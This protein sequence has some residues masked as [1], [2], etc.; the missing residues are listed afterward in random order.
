MTEPKPD[1]TPKKAARLEKHERRRRVFARLLWQGLDP[2]EAFCKAEYPVIGVTVTKG[3]YTP[4]Q[5]QTKAEAMRGEWWCRDLVRSWDQSP[6]DSIR[7]SLQEAADVFRMAMRQRGEDGLPTPSALRAAENVMDRGGYGRSQ[8]IERG[9]SDLGERKTR[10]EL[11]AAVETY[12][13]ALKAPIQRP[14]ELE[15]IVV[16]SQR[17]DEDEATA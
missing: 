9:S 4:E 7:A 3:G 13:A 11:V 10:A 5:A 16:K 1:A 17:V 6:D 15:C 14:A 12:L 2:Y 8:T